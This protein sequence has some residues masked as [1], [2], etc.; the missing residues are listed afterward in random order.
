MTAKQQKNGG[1]DGKI[2][3]KKL[4]LKD[5]GF[6]VQAA[7][8]LGIVDGIR[9]QDLTFSEGQVPFVVEPQ[10]ALKIQLTGA[11][12][13]IVGSVIP[14]YVINSL[15]GKI[16]LIGGLFRDSDGGGL[17]GAKYQINGSIFNPEV[18]FSALK[19]MAP[20]ILGKLV[21]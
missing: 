11:K 9:G 19:S 14:A 10:R 4:S 3:I 12:I 2:N 21:K 18:S 5:P 17:I 6:L 13:A 1:F 7:T 20:G 15:H 8:I 16:P